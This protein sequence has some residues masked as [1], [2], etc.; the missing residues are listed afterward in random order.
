MRFY[1]ACYDPGGDA[2]D[3]SFWAWQHPALKADMLDE[4]YYGF[5]SK[6]LPLPSTQS[7]RFLTLPNGLCGGCAGISHQWSCWYRFVDGGSDV[8]GRPGRIVLLAAFFNPLDGQGRNTS[9]VLR[10]AIIQGYAQQAPSMCPIPPPA[11]ME[12]LFSEVVAS[13]DRVQREKLEGESV[14][15]FDGTNAMNAGG[16]LIANIP[17]GNSFDCTVQGA[18]GGESVRVQLLHGQRLLAKEG[19]MSSVEPDGAAMEIEPVE[20][21]LS[22]AP[23]TAPN[24]RGI[25]PLSTRA[26]N[27]PGG[28]F[29]TGI[30]LITIIGVR[31]IIFIAGFAVGILTGGILW[32]KG[33]NTSSLTQRALSSSQK[34]NS[35]ANSGKAKT[36]SGGVK[37]AADKSNWRGATPKPP[38]R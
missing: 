38:L 26:R 34:P 5:A 17:P 22:H 3:G 8:R 24:L 23:A 32:K 16:D 11:S 9:G 13:V 19:G 18:L 31:I 2:T 20:V 4:F 14:V 1:L 29:G 21:Q 27:R 33:P 10:N 6:H 7:A 30:P 12:L 37:T 35:T 36:A 28:R 15:N 25:V